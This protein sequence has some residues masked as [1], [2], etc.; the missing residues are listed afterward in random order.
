M[1][2]KLVKQSQLSSSKM[3]HVN[4]FFVLIYIL[5]TFGIS[6]GI[7]LVE[8]CLTAIIV[9]ETRNYFNLGHPVVRCVHNHV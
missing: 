7:I 1:N 5:R 2:Q 4:F 3:D 6:V 8:C 9:C